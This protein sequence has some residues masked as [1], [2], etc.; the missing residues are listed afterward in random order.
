MLNELFD[1]L[2]K[3]VEFFK[4]EDSKELRDRL[5]RTN[6]LRYWYCECVKDLEELWSEISGSE[7]AYWYCVIV[8]DRKEVWSKISNSEWA[9]KYCS[10]VKD[11]PEVRKYVK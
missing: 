2:G 11:R 9:C 10:W 6:K 7:W 5:I 1:N 3:F 4:A 8:K